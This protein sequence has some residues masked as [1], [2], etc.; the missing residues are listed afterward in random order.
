M[1]F[2]DGRYRVVSRRAVACDCVVFYDGSY[3]V[4]SRRAF[5]CDGDYVVFYDGRLFYLFIEGL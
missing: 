3:R 4:V 5:A 1:V 2:Y